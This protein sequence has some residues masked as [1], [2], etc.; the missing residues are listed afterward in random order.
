MS[1]SP[2]PGGTTGSAGRPQRIPAVSKRLY[3]QNLMEK[4]GNA[5]NGQLRIGKGAALSWQ[6]RFQDAV[7]KGGCFWR[8][9]TLN[10][11][12]IPIAPE[13]VSH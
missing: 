11:S 5:G 8:N 7:L 6:R 9:T 10:Q 12:I 4:L 3:F 13:I 1:L 2:P